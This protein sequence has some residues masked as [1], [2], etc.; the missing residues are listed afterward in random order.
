MARCCASPSSLRIAPGARR[1]GG[2]VGG[3]L[4]HLLMLLLVWLAACGPPPPSTAGLGLPAPDSARLAQLVARYEPAGRARWQQPEALLAALQLPARARV[5]ELGATT[6]YVAQALL[7]GPAPRLELV[8]PDS[9]L[10]RLLRR[11]FGPQ[12]GV[13]VRSA[14]PGPQPGPQ[15]GSTRYQRIVVA[16]GLTRLP[17]AEGQW[18]QLLAQLAPGGQ[19]VLLAPRP[20]AA[21]FVPADSAQP[22]QRWVQRLQ[23]AGFRSFELDS[24]LFPYHVLIT[25][26]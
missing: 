23:Q 20:G 15:S 16:D 24:L 4:A 17:L 7:A 19:L 18:R 1:R 10:R 13:V 5:L 2:G 11:R 6:G 25:A 26:Q 21:P 22:A 3:L 12:A 8:E 14:V 9:L